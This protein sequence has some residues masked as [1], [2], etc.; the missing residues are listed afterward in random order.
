MR[1][2]LFKVSIL[3]FLVICYCFR[4]SVSFSEA[5]NG[6]IWIGD[7]AEDMPLYDSE[8]YSEHTM[9]EGSY[10]KFKYILYEPSGYRFIKNLPLIVLLHG[11]GEKGH[12]LSKIW[13]H[14]PAP[15]L[16]SGELIVPAI[17][18]LPQVDGSSWSAVASDLKDLID[19]VADIYYCDRKRISIT[20]HSMGGYGVFRMLKKYPNYFSAAVPMSADPD[21]DYSCVT[22]TPVWIIYGDD[23]GS[24]SSKTVNRIA[25]SINNAGG[26]CKV[27]VLKNTGHPIGFMWYDSDYQMFQW[28]ISHSRDDSVVIDGD[29]IVYDKD[30][31]VPAIEFTDEELEIMFEDDYRDPVTGALG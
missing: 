15:Q 25:D 12:K 16:K 19:Y 14:S 4:F 8:I 26:Y 10:G 3:F 21:E 27:T 11:S 22:S 1:R 30:P 5:D 24:V 13:N 20:G 7:D 18:L 31:D 2:S 29:R 17:V 28:M 23:D 6:G 9:T